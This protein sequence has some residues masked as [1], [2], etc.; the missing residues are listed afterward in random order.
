MQP[1]QPAPMPVPMPAPAPAPMQMAHGGPSGTAIVTAPTPAMIAAARA[2]A[3]RATSAK[4]PFAGPLQLVLLVFG[5]I[6]IGAF[7]TPHT[8]SPTTFVWDS[9]GALEGKAKVMPILLAAAG[10]LGVLLGA[11]PLASTGR[12]AAAAALG[13]VAIV[14]PALA[15]PAEFTWQ[16]VSFAVG[17]MLIPAGLL[18]RGA[19]P[20]AG[21]GRILTT[22]GAIAFLVP[23]FVPEH[24]KMP[25]VGLFDVLAD[26]KGKEKFVAILF[27][28]YPLL[29]VLSLS[30]W[31]PGPGRGPAPMFAW[32]WILLPLTVQFTMLIV[33]GKIG[34]V[35]KA[36][37]YKALFAMG[38]DLPV[39][40]GLVAS[41]YLAYAAFGLA[42]LL[43]KNLER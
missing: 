15:L 1:M 25:I 14:Y 23:W 24:D 42:T 33:N 11:I 31:L 32:L 8:T 21:L 35:V 43:G 41:A 5:V 7:V 39:P 27:L 2:S 40:L 3:S 12:A 4:D 9:L 6:L 34:A 13:I 28:L 30:A 37:P 16:L 29:A 17:S 26:G 10:L 18:L 38:G 22:I 36:G 19:Y 20:N